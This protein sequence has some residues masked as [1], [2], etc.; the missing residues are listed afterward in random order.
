MNDF[1]KKP[2]V[3][4]L[5][6]KGEKGETGDVSKENFDNSINDL[7]D[8]ISNNR[9]RI[10]DAQ[11][12]IKTANSR[13]D[14]LI[15]SSGSDS[16]A[17]VIDARTGYDG[18]SYDTLGTAIRTQ[19]NN[20]NDDLATLKTTQDNAIDLEKT[21]FFN[22]ETLSENR[23]DWNAEPYIDNMLFTGSGEKTAENTGYYISQFM[24]IDGGKTYYQ[25]LN[26]PICLY[27]NAHKYIRTVKYNESPFVADENAKYARCSVQRSKKASK[28]ISESEQVGTQAGYVT[29]FTGDKVV[30]ANEELQKAIQSE[31]ENIIK[32]VYGDNR[33]DVTE[34]HFEDG[35]II[36]YG[37]IIDRTG[38][39]ISHLMK[40][41]PNTT[42]YKNEAGDGIFYD[43]KM[44]VVGLSNNEG[45]TF[46]SPDNAFYY[47][48]SL[49]N[50]I[51]SKFYV[52]TVN[53]IS[54]FG[55]TYELE[56]PAKSAVEK[57]VKDLK[58]TGEGVIEKRIS[59]I[60]DSLNGTSPIEKAIVTLLTMMVQKL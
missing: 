5:M 11:N 9:S 29:P 37:N 24:R 19:A 56:Q 30:I 17:E 39:F 52:S 47:R 31:Q 35:K 45:L 15:V 46:T 36:Q 2:L 32:T 40:I 3:K 43:E 10:D 41:N 44:N 13:I 14:N 42:Y 60:S 59:K 57:V 27:D 16:S 8:L 51:A 33:F 26:S 6:L 1:L 4:V 20:L 25:N 49:S 50:G 12:G 28:Y 18:T 58:G 38:Y 53:K 55:D 22:I 7:T 34:P 23:F 48:C 21:D 54:S